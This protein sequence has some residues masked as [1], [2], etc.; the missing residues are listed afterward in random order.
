MKI[1]SLVFDHGGETILVEVDSKLPKRTIRV[2]DSAWFLGLIDQEVPLTAPREDAA[3]QRGT[4]RRRR[5]RRRAKERP[6]VSLVGAKQGRPGYGRVAHRLLANPSDI[7]Q[8]RRAVRVK[9]GALSP[10]Q[11]N[12]LGARFPE[13]G[14]LPVPYSELMKVYGMRKDSIVK[15]LRRGLRALG[16]RQKFLHNRSRES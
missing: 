7:E 1:S 16:I 10:L 8:I 11:L 6:T 15:E 12:L 4:K 9:D 13:D 3:P 14:V 5:V 2:P